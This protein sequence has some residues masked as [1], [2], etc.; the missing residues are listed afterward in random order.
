MSRQH[1][2]LRLFRGPI[3]GEWMAVKVGKDGK[4]ITDKWHLDGVDE[5][6]DSIAGQKDRP[7]EES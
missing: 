5:L 4:T 2:T 6:L 3:T 7:E 1:G